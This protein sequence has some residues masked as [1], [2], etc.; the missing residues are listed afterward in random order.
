M[1]FEFKDVSTL[2]C[3]N[4][5]ALPFSGEC[6]V[7]SEDGDVIALIKA[8]GFNDKPFNNLYVDLFEVRIKS[9]GYG[10]R[11]IKDLFNRFKT[12]ERIDA[13]CM[14]GCE[15]FWEGLGA[16]FINDC[17]ACEYLIQCESDGKACDVRTSPSFLLFRQ[18]VLE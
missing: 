6:G 14:E 12:L 1:K 3:K 18:D 4:D 15:L 9:I 13:E 10:T 5:F 11:C 8:R 7:W 16:Y 17:D 2:N